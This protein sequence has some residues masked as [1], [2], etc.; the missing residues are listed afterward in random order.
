MCISQI[1]FLLSRAKNLRIVINNSNY[2]IIKKIKK[3]NNILNTD[4]L[5]FTEWY[6]YVLLFLW[7]IMLF[8]GIKYFYLLESHFKPKYDFDKGDKYGKNLLISSFVIG[9]LLVIIFTFKPTQL[10]EQSE[11]NWDYI[12]YGL[13]S[14]FILLLALNAFVSI[15]NYKLYV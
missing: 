15:R 12:N 10:N 14:L 2:N 6:H 5:T 4:F 13:Y 7:L 3:M 1:L 8:T 9:L 11:L